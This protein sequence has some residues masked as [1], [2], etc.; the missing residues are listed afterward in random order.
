[1]KRLISISLALLLL[2]SCF[3]V[4]VNASTLSYSLRIEGIDKNF[5]DA[6]IEIESSDEINLTIADALT[7]A[8]SDSNL[9]IVG[10]DTGF[11]TSVMG[12]ENAKFGGYDGWQYTV[13]DETPMVGIGEYQI[14]NG[15]AVVL[16]YGDYPCQIPVI[17]SSKASE[18]VL[19]FSSY[20]TV[21]YQDDSGEWLSKSDWAPITDA[22][23]TLDGAEFKTDAAGTVT[24]EASQYKNEIN[25]QIEK[26]SDKGAPMVR[27]LPADYMVSLTSGASEATTA[28]SEATSAVETTE[29]ATTVPAT[30]TAEPVTTVTQPET[31]VP[32]T[33][34]T[35]PTTVASEPEATEPAVN[36][37]TVVNVPKDKTLYVAQ[38]YKIKADIKNAVG[39]TSYISS[40]KSVARVDKNGK[41]TALKKG[42]A[43]ITVKNNKVSKTF[44]VTVKNP[45]LN[46]KSVSLKKGQKFTIKITGKYGSQTYTSSNKSIA[47]V[48]KN[49]K[50]TAKNYGKA[51]ITV[52]TNKSVTLKLKVTV[53]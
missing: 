19:K 28:A 34:S 31:T 30:E 16:Y 18:G 6:D 44:K 9:N 13:N 25:V 7:K 51:V 1:M 53:K 48:S 24:F 26:K 5:Y 37:D 15:D 12:E 8:N 11:I 29:P 36:P 2:V 27:R 43:V 47:K 3:M 14:K 49:G 20:D 40:R 41:I 38:T 17:D 10:I 33:E 32:A 42:E 45:K 52:K 21:W 35:E 23:V 22:D 4:A 46:R 50:V 39:N